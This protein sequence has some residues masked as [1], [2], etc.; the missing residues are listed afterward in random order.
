MKSI[1]SDA[2]AALIDQANAVASLIAAKDQLDTI[3]GANFPR[4][5]SF[6]NLLQEQQAIAANDTLSGA[7]QAFNE[8]FYLTWDQL[9]MVANRMLDGPPG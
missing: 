4:L 7:F 9:E 6:L 2:A 8:L 3:A 1:R 5:A